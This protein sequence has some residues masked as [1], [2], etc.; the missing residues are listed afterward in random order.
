MLKSHLLATKL[1][2]PSRPAQWVPRPFLTQQLQAGLK[3]N[4]PL[5][6]VSAPAG[7]GK[8]TAISAWVHTLD[9][10]VAWLSLDAGDDDP[11]RFFT[12]LIAALQMI[13]ASLGEEMEAALSG[14]QLPP[15]EV[16][17]AML[18]NY[19]LDVPHR[20]LLVLDD[21]HVIQDP[22]I[23]QVLEALILNPPP[24][25][26]V[27]IITREDPPLPLA[28]LRAHNRLTEIRAQDLRFTGQDTARFLEALGLS[29][30]TTDMAV[31]EK[32]T[33]GWIAGLQLAAIALQ[34]AAAVESDP[35]GWDTALGEDGGGNLDA[36]PRFVAPTAGDLH[37][38][39]DSPAIDAGDNTAVPVGIVTDLD[40]RSRFIDVPF[41]P[42][43]GSG[44]P[45]LV[46]MGAYEASFADLSLAKTVTPA[47]AAPGEMLT[48]TLTLNNSSS[49]T[50]TQVVLT[51]TL[52]AHLSPQAVLAS[53]ITITDTGVSPAF[54]WH[55]ADLA[56]D[57]SGVI[58]LS[59][60]LTVPLAAGTYTNT[61]YLSAAN[62]AWPLNNSA[63]ITYTVANVAPMFT[64]TAVPT[65][66]QD[67]PYTYAITASDGNG[68]PLTITAPVLPDWLSLTDNGDGTAVLSG[69]PS[70][71]DV[72]D[73]AV[74]LRVTDKADRYS[75]QTFSVTVLAKPAFTLYLPLLV[76][77]ER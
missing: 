52:P 43:S 32:K 13:D 23:L 5:T 51:D 42:D 22:V 36:D 8:T 48:F 58:T 70:R 9:C 33:E 57:Q 74:T 34:S 16:I 29:L 73:H 75:E 64:S 30:S 55:V 41:V 7:F 38:G 76:Q 69:T 31:L 15:P 18:S 65:A 6:L 60:V 14:G 59:A 24:P 3:R 1:H 37:L 47:V 62:D 63:S 53:G 27:A 11:G 12:Y 19:M 26:H 10:P 72:G 4:R 54:V 77:G 45:P 71:A 28:R 68:D 21:F 61:A 25:L 35:S 44:T 40:G 17:G 20:F 67:A 39:P 50:A 46:D 66:T 56:P 49:L 2:L